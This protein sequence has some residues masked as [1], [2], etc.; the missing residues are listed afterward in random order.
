MK[1][2]KEVMAGMRR[3]LYLFEFAVKLFY[4]I[5]LRSFIPAR[6]PFS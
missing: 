3:I 4:L 5:I 6:Y 1:F 2:I